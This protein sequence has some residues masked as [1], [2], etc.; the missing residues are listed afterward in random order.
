MTDAYI[1]DEEELRADPVT[2]IS[3]VVGLALSAVSALL[4]PKPQEPK[5]PPNV[6]TD[7]I[8]GR[9]RFAPQSAFDSVQELSRLGATVPL[10]F[11]RKGVRVTGT[12][13][14]SQM[15]SYGISQ[16]LRVITLFSSGEIEGRPDWA[17]YAIGDTLLEN[18]TNSKLALYFKGNGGRILEGGSHRYPQGK[19]ADV[20]PSDAFSVFWHNDAKYRGYF[21]GTRTP[22]TQ[23]QFGAY[24]PIP[25]GQRFKLNYEVVT[26]A[27]AVKDRQPLRNK[28]AKIKKE[29]PK[30]INVISRSDT[31]AVL[32]I[33]AGALNEDDFEPHGLV[34]VNNAVEGLRIEADEEFGVG[35]EYLVGT[36]LA[37]A[38]NVP[39]EPWRLGRT[40]DIHLHWIEGK[41]LVDVMR[42]SD[43]KAGSGT[44]QVQRVA[45][46]TVSNNRSCDATEIGIKST[47]F[48]QMN[49]FANVNSDPGDEA[50]K[51]IEDE[52]G[53]FVLGSIQAYISRLSFFRLQIR[54]LGS[55]KGWSDLSNG[56]LFCVQGR[57]PQPHYNFIRVYHPHEQYEFRLLP[58]PGNGALRYYRNKEVWLL[59][60]G[61]EVGFV[62]N[63]FHVVFAGKRLFLD[64]TAMCNKEW[65]LGKPPVVK[66]SIVG[67]SSYQRGPALQYDWTANGT[68]GK[69]ERTGPSRWEYRYWGEGVV[70]YKTSQLSGN[71]NPPTDYLTVGNDRYKATERLDSRVFRVK[72]ET[73]KPSTAITFNGNVTASG[74]H[75]SGLVFSVKTYANGFK[76]W[77]IVKGGSGYRAGDRVF[78]PVANVT[79][80][81]Q[82]DAGN[83]LKNNLNPYD[84]IADGVTYREE[85]SSHQDGPEHEIVY[86][87]EF[88]AQKTPNYDALAIAGL[89]INSSR[90]WT[91]FSNLSA[92]FKR[93]VKV[94]RLVTS[95]RSASNLLPEIAY[96]LLTDPLIGAGE[97]IGKDQV[98]RD[99]MASAARF[100]QANDF[101]W[102]GVTD[103]RLNLREWIFEQAAYCLL[104]FTVIGGKFS[105]VP[106]VP[107][108]SDGKIDHK[109]KPEIKALFTD[110]NIRKLKVSFLSPEE[111]QMFRGVGIWRK[112]K[113]NGFPETRTV[114]VRL[115]DASGGSERDPEETFDMSGFGTSQHHVLTFLKYAIMLRKAVDH[116]ITFVAT[117]QAAMNL[118]PGDYFRLVSSV[119]HT[120]R[121]G[122]GSIGPDGSITSIDPLDGSYPILYWEPGTVGVKHGT[123]IASDNRCNDAALYGVVFTLLDRGPVDRVYKC[124]SIGYAEDGLVEIAAS[125][126]PLTDSGTLAT[127]DWDETEFI[128]DVG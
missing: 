14:W 33:G 17:G 92:Y 59:H 50:L 66:G 31:G 40:K 48:K 73:L 109:A 3:L 124:E 127:L 1:P 115:S 88:V 75:G 56:T 49:G 32:R 101:T 5:Q 54:P 97:L 102:D 38:V 42:W 79:L 58:Y 119:T 122:N 86:V 23:A 6:R 103:E 114:T 85:R 76:T 106:S 43:T 89:R 108:T 11:S 7:D 100:C 94:E 111:R 46:G 63:G 9:S 78:L 123:L 2:V 69:A 82:T 116:G 110:G 65:I 107:V 62:Q 57:T 96:A 30:R 64:E 35:N 53:S 91:A 104:D 39:E 128:V 21:C 47:V 41:G 113:T 20:E 55:D 15:L 112:E 98:D 19:I 61:L 71:A 52:N 8:K 34:D 126:A 84:A 45:I 87:N 99:R 67:V 51:E 90:E 93:G 27:D 125:H 117:P 81:T 118:T 28:R 12:L 120:S 72:R 60:Q 105:L 74:G 68:N 70:G 26:I 4:A 22:S 36:G 80:N 10:V 16:Q 18:Y 37:T 44:L 95:G 121:F 83:L 29:Y 24:A 25:N 13:L 77:K